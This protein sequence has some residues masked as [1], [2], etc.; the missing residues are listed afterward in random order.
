MRPMSHSTSD[1]NGRC[2]ANLKP[3]GRN[4]FQVSHMGAGCQGFGLSSTAFP[5]HKQG[6]G[7]K[8]E[9]PNGSQCPMGPGAF[10]VRTVATRPRRWAPRHILLSCLHCGKVLFHFQRQSRNLLGTLSWADSLVLLESGICCSIL[11]WPVE[12]PVNSIGIPL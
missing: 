8:A 2:Y 10:K 6:A 12:F 3:G 5:G 7:C 9:L 4:F 1:R 11:F